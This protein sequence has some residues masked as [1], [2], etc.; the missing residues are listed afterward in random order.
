MQRLTPR[1]ARVLVCFTLSV[2]GDAAWAEPPASTSGDYAD[3][4]LIPAPKNTTIAERVLK[5]KA[6]QFTKTQIRFDVAIVTVDSET[7]ERLYQAIGESNVETEINKAATPDEPDTIDGKEASDRF[8][9]HR[10][11]TA[12]VVSTAVLDADTTGQVLALIKASDTSQIVG[13][14]VIIAADGQ[15]AAVE[16]QVQRPFLSRLQKVQLGEQSSIETGIEVL[17]EGIR[18][19]VQA[20]SADDALQVKTRLKQSR[21]VDVKTFDVFGFGDDKKVLQVPSHEVQLVSAAQRLQPQE[22]L[23]LDPYFESSRTIAKSSQL[24]IVANV[25]Y[26]KELFESTEYQNVTL[27]TLVFLT[28]SK[29]AP[30]ENRQANSDDSANQTRR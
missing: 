11:T 5:G 13:R 2:L 15:T 6:F 18:L 28:P 17:N 16:Q 29:L 7:R 14:P 27:H 23:L 19:A 30:K 4:K 20:D 10:T 8:S 26:V 1:V 9:S 25:P 3:G 21:V 22:T 12:S 24:P